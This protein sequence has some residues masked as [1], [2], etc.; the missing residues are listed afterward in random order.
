MVPRPPLREP[1][2]RLR[3]I[4]PVERLENVLPIRTHAVPLMR[5]LSIGDAE[6]AERLGCLA[7]VEEDVAPLNALCTSGARYGHLLRRVLDQ[8]A[9]AE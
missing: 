6:T 5:A 1:P 7:L 3:P 9:A 2:R 4:M 8:L